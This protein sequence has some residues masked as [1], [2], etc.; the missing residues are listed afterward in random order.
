MAGDNSVDPAKKWWW[1]VAVA[2]PIV[3]AVIAIV[4]DMLRTGADE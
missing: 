4:P 1:L 2:V 3:V